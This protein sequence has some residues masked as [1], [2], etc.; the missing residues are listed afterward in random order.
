MITGRSSALRNLGLHVMQG[1]IDNGYR[2]E[3]FTT[4][5]N[6]GD[7]EVILSPGDRVS[8]LILFPMITPPVEHSDA[9]S[10]SD[11]GVAGFGSTGR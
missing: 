8:Q 3:L 2:G 5:F 6:L 11:R 10:P 9:L 4:L 7:G 1:I